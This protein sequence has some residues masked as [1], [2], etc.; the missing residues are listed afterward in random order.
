MLGA[1]RVQFLDK[2]NPNTSEGNDY[3]QL[4]FYCETDE[5]LPQTP[6]PDGGVMR[7]RDFISPSEITNYVKWGK[8]GDAIF[9]QATALYLSLRGGPPAGG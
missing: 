9:S 4:R 7:E 5:I 2:P 1:Q 8:I 3:Y 6:D